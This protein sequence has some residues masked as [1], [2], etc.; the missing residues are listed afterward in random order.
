[1]T[2]RHA[3]QLSCE[4]CVKIYEAKNVIEGPV[5]STSETPNTKRTYTYP[6]R[7]LFVAAKM[8]N[9]KFVVELIRLYPDLIWKLDDKKRSL[10]TLFLSTTTMTA[11]FSVSFFV[12]YHK[13]LQLLK[14]IWNA[15]AEKPK[16]EIDNILR[17]P[18]VED[19]PT[20]RNVDHAKQLSCE[21]CV[22][23]YEAKNVIKGPVASTSET[24]NI[25]RTYTYPS[26]ILFV[27]AKM[28]NTKF[29]VELIRLYPDLIWK[30]DNKNRSI[31]HIA[32]KRRHKGIYSLMYEIG[33]MKDLITPIRDV[34]GNNMLHLVGKS[35][36]RKRRLQEV[37]GVA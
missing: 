31:F 11:A 26:R 8:G 27:A 14:L 20:T 21:C 25:N 15:I 19:K 34:K 1:M 5:A 3:K 2:K 32:I 28:G 7:I 18:A 9:T 4:C 24:P 12:L 35:A 22:K 10:S 6:S 17:G 36:S 30:L 37:S 33:S 16:K 23:I 29:V 13:A